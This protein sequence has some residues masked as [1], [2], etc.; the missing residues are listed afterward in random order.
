MGGKE[1]VF[2]YR[3]KRS[4][5][6]YAALLLFFHLIG[7]YTVLEYFGGNPDLGIVSYNQ[8]CSKFASAKAN[9][10][11]PSVNVPPCRGNDEDQAGQLD[12]DDCLAACTHSLQVAA[13]FETRAITAELQTQN[14]NIKRLQPDPHLPTF[15]RPPRTA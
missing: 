5:C 15:Y 10:I 3:R 11:T 9:S 13:F 8:V 4:M 7:N 14:Q 1:I 2:N 12:G 6:Q